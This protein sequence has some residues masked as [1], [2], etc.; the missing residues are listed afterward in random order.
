M[1]ALCSQEDFPLFFSW[2]RTLGLQEIP[3]QLSRLE[4]V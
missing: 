2:Q 3:L 1:L 4:I